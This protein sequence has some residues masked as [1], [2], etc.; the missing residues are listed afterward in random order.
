MKKNKFH[1][2]TNKLKGKLKNNHKLDVCENCGVLRIAC[3]PEH[4]KSYLWN[5]EKILCKT[6]KK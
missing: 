3:D 5:R 6:T 4:G 2:W 1:V